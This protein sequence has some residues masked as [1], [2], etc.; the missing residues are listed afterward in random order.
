MSLENRRAVWQLEFMI[1]VCTCFHL[2]CLQYCTIFN[3]I[4][5]IYIKSVYLISALIGVEGQA[6][7]ITPV[8]PVVTQGSPVLL[9]C[10]YT[11]T[12]TVLYCGWV[13]SEQRIARLSSS[14][15]EGGGSPVNTTLYSYTCPGGDV[16]TWTIKSVLFEERAFVWRCEI[17][18][19]S[20]ADVSNSVKIEVTG[21]FKKMLNGSWV[22]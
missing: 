3:E 2:T 6:V 9:T 4:C 22:N 14:C 19:V 11:G 18:H 12:D 13:R 8:S 20:E 5:T 15:L 10:T 1:L 21:R 17:Y 7:K 16:F